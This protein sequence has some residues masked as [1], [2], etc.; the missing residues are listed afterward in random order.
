MGFWL[1][2]FIVKFIFLSLFKTH[3]LRDR[4]YFEITFPLNTHKSAL[5][6]ILLD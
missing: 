6:E 1:L 4:R 2:C 5:Q 3:F